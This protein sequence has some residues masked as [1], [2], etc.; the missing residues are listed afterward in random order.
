MS[1]DVLIMRLPQ[2]IQTYD[3]LTACESDPMLPLGALEDVRRHIDATFPDTDWSDP[4]WGVWHGPEGSIE[5]SL[6]RDGDAPLEHLMLHVRAGDEI[7]G[8]IVALCEG[9]GWKA[10]DT[11][12]T[13]FLVSAADTSGLSGWRSLRDRAAGRSA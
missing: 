11:S 13:E 5:F 6:G 7:V 9:A 12:A 3:D 1:W 2:E 4:R 8:R 10:L